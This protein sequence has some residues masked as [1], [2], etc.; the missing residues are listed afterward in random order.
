MNDPAHTTGYRR[1]FGERG[2]TDQFIRCVLRPVESLREVEEEWLE[3][4]WAPT[5]LWILYGVLV[6]VDCLIYG[7]TLPLVTP[8]EGWLHWG[9]TFTFAVGVAWFVF[10]PMV[11]LATGKATPVVAQ[12][13]LVAMGYAAGA[14]EVGFIVNLC[15]WAF[16]SAGTCLITFNLVCLAAANV[17]A[18]AAVASQFHGVGVPAWKSLGLWLAAFNGSLAAM[19]ALK[20]D[21]F[22]P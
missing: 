21:L 1:G 19:L 5:G 22:T 11:G 13:C 10:A 18:S 7:A 17:I 8:L 6:T 14:L 15:F 16:G 3:R 4:R 20:P 2:V 9:L 12:S